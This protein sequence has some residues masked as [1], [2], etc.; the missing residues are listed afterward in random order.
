MFNFFWIPLSYIP[1]G[2]HDIDYTPRRS[3]GE[4]SWSKSSSSVG[5]PNRDLSMCEYSRSTA[6][7]FTNTGSMVP[8]TASATSW[9]MTGRNL[10]R[11]TLAHAWNRG[12]R[13]VNLPC[14]RVHFQRWRT[15]MTG[16]QREDRWSNRSLVNRCTYRY[17]GKTM[18][19][20]EWDVYCVRELKSRR[21]D[22]TS[23]A[24]C[25]KTVSQQGPGR[26]LGVDFVILLGW[27]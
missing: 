5:F 27:L 13:S 20:F 10:W 23:R 8:W 9:P 6:N 16:P 1:R 11:R 19:K 3:P 24:E 17:D 21:T 18:M 26:L 15:S 2:D 25:R 22:L 14:M 4:H 7:F 12:T